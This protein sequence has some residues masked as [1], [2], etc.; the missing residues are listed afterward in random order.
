MKL[1][2]WIIKMLGGITK[3]DHEAERLKHE[4]WAIKYLTGKNGEVTPDVCYY[5]PFDGDDI[6]IVR[7]RISVTNGVVKG[8]K[9]APW[10]S[11]VV[12]SGLVTFGEEGER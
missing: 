5:H 6:V 7:S 8:V 12:L 10:C 2:D 1:N 9:I 11:Q 4:L 3:A